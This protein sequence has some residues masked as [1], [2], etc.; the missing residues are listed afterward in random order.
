MRRPSSWSS[1]DAFGSDSPIHEM[2]T[3][4]GVL[5]QHFEVAL[6]PS[7]QRNL[8]GQRN[9]R[10][11][12][13]PQFLALRARASR[14]YGA[15]DGGGIFVKRQHNRVLDERLEGM[16]LAVKGLSYTNRLSIAAKAFEDRH[17]TNGEAP[18]R[19]QVRL[20]MSGDCSVPSTQFRQGVGS[21]TG[22]TS[23]TSQPL[24]ISGLQL[25]LDQPSIGR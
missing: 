2:Q 11:Q 16:Q 3:H 15:R 13:V 17:R 7:R 1:T 19:S 6:I 23:L 18:E 10:N 5:A 25:A 21:R 12:N 24:A 8:T 20:C 4:L 14:P 22:S 9:A